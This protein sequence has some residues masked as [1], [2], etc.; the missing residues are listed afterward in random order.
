MLRLLAIAIL[1][2]AISPAALRLVS[3]CSEPAPN[4]EAIAA[5]QRF[6]TNFCYNQYRS[7]S[8]IARCLSNQ[9]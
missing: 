1:A 8:D 7:Q 6:Q 4:I 9:F 2:A 3:A 5:Q